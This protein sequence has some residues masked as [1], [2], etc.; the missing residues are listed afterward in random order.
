MTE[1]LSEFSC[2]FIKYGLE[3]TRLWGQERIKGSKKGHEEKVIN[4]N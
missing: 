3:M 4:E 1:K 2:S